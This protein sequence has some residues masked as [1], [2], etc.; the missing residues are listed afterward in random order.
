[1]MFSQC[2]ITDNNSFHLKGN[3]WVNSFFNISHI[4]WIVGKACEV[5]PKGLRRLM[6]L[7]WVH[8]A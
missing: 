7:D 8:L 4:T 5:G 3:S 1:L 6:K 2:H